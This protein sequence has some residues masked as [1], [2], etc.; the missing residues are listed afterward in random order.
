MIFF[1]RRYGYKDIKILVLKTFDKNWSKIT[2]NQE[3]SPQYWI[4]KFDVG[5]GWVVTILNC[6]SLGGCKK[7]LTLN[8]SSVPR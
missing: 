1:L 5:F 6:A 4:G 3:K 7:S 8:F 2:K